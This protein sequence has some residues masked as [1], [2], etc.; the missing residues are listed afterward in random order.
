MCVL[1]CPGCAAASRI[2]LSLGCTVHSIFTFNRKMLRA[3]PPA[4]P[5]RFSRVSLTRHCLRSNRQ[6]THRAS[7]PPG[8]LLAFNL[9]VVFTKSGLAQQ[10]QRRST[11]L[12]RPLARHVPA[13][14][15]RRHSGGV[16]GAR[17]QRRH[18]CFSS[19]ANCHSLGDTV[20]GELKYAQRGHV[21]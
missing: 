5:P 2:F 20:G 4:R 15:A 11:R 3:P 13:T 8:T 9:S 6:Q 19:I 7:A 18:V 21:L 1:L 17:G 12:A 16:G 14:L 10:V